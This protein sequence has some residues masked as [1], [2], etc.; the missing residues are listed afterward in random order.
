MGWQ[1]IWR[2]KGAAIPDNPTMA[3]VMAL[4]GY[5]T[6]AGT[7]SYDAFTDFAA[8]TANR[9]DL[10]AGEHF[11]EI[12]CGAGAWLYYFY[13]A[14]M[15]VTGADISA[16]HLTV[17]RHLMPDGTFVNCDAL[18]LPFADSSYD[19]AVAGACFEYLVED[20][21]PEHS[22]AELVRVL[23]P[24]GRAAITDIPDNNK[25]AESESIRRGALGEEE[26]DRLY[27]DLPHQ[28]FDRD[29]MI[30]LARR[31]GVRATAT[32]QQIAGYGN[33]PHRFNLWFEKP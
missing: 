19:C 32:T 4:N 26:Y 6:G 15:S 13:Q 11:L 23:R 3:D 9:F 16:G 18:S 20:D 22:F 29:D 30:D 14:G 7:M 5:D 25:R 8:Y 17:A 10:V 27:A 12:G 21:K 31:L 2:R 28:Y 24:G 1:E 33:S